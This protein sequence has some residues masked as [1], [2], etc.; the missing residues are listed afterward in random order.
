MV[1]AE[2]RGADAEATAGASVGVPAP[3]VSASRAGSRSVSFAQPILLLV[4]YVSTHL[5]HAENVQSRRI[6][7]T[8]ESGR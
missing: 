4:F 6:A 8:K 1:G 3:S 7:A 2:A 5:V